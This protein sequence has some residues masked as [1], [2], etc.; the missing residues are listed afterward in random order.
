MGAGKAVWTINGQM[1]HDMPH[2]DT[3]TFCKARNCI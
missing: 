1:A 2:I 3:G